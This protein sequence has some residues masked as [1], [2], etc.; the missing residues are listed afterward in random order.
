MD[1][2]LPLSCVLD[3]QLGR[4]HVVPHRTLSLRRSSPFVQYLT[5]DDTRLPEHPL[6][7]VKA[8]SAEA[9][10]TYVGEDD[11]VRAGGCGG[12]H[13]AEDDN[14]GGEPLCF[15]DVVQ[16]VVD[17]LR[18]VGGCG[19]GAASGVVLCGRRVVADDCCWAV[20]SRTPALY[21]PRDVFLAMRNSTKFLRDIHHQTDCVRVGDGE[22]T[23]EIALARVVGENPANEFRV[24]VPYRLVKTGDTFSITKW[25]ETAYIGV[26]QRATDVCF[27]SLMAW[28]STVHSAN[29]DY[30]VQNINGARLL[31]RGVEIDAVLRDALLHQAEVKS[32]GD[33]I[34]PVSVLLLAVDVVFES[35]SLPFYIISA[36]VRC[37]R[38]D[39]LRDPQCVAPFIREDAD[40]D[41]SAHKTANDGVSGNDYSGEIDIEDVYGDSVAFF[42][43]F[44]DVENWNRHVDF[45]HGTGEEEVVLQSSGSVRALTATK[46][47]R[48]FVVA[49]ERDDLASTK[50]SMLKRGLPLE[51][52]QPE[53]LT[54]GSEVHAQQWRA[55]LAQCILLAEE[56]K[57][58]S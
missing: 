54:C 28:D 1:L 2:R 8:Q 12:T 29:Y 31:E 48:F 57:R 16:W 3:P 20:P 11:W 53:L 32:P 37:F 51:F 13:C 5:S 23:V 52:L 19:D 27:P 21:S 14:D 17:A 47:R 30:F 55:R 49:S 18:T 33:V 50:E 4:R 44:R 43:L 22:A 25:E 9:Y 42:R 39:R 35:I 38:H 45:Y 40:D 15:D 41:T 34:N 6:L 58:K 24:F 46:D 36:K 7:T 26:C 10:E 56:A